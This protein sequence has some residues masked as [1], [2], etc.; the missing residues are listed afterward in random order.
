MQTM[1][2][3]GAY[4]LHECKDEVSLGRGDE[5]DCHIDSLGAKSSLFVWGLKRI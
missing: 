4:A 2:V 3:F 1:V 5:K